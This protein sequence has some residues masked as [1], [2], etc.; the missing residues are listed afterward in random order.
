MKEN[1]DGKWHSGKQM[2][3]IHKTVSAVCTV[4]HC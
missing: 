4:R 1:M 3:A 2:T